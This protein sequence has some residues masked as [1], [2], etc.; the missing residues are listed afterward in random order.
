MMKRRFFFLTLLFLLM[1][2]PASAAQGPSALVRTAPLK[3][4]PLIS[5]LVGYG[6]VE[7]DMRR[8]VNISFPRS[9]EV[10]RLL[11]TDGQVVV[12]GAPLLRFRTAPAA[13][14]AYEQAVSAVAY[15]RAE[16]KRTARLLA[17]H[18]ATG[19]QLAAARKALNDARAALQAQRRLGT[20]TA[21]EQVTAPFAGTVTRL[22]VQQG[23]LV[24][25]GATVLQLTPEGALQ[26]DLGVEPEE[27]HRVKV[28]MPVRVTSVFDASR[29][30]E[31]RVFAVHGIINPRTRLVDVL[32]SLQG[33]R[34]AF[35]P[36][37]QVRGAIV[38]KHETAWAVP[39]SAVLR[40]ARGAYIIQVADGRARRVA[41]HTGIVTGTLVGIRGSFDP[42][43]PVVVLGNYELQDGMAVRE[44]RP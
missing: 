24:Q 13:S 42:R 39:R 43:L 3:K 15:A 17:Q 12:K 10:A 41:V 30:V 31:G 4:A 16:V 28:G 14:L 1:G 8:T 36:G 32:V 7:A 37:M 5:S 2:S 29:Q 27:A 38:L 20:G 25:A 19:A 11:V 40:D 9:G 44:E 23:D 21:S 6:T 18:L 34:A 33:K 26:A 22:Q 35:L